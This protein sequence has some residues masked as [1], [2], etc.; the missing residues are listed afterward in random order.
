M[1]CRPWIPCEGCAWLLLEGSRALAFYA[2]VWV[3]VEMILSGFVRCVRDS[4]GVLDLTLTHSVQTRTKHTFT[5]ARAGLGDARRAPPSAAHMFIIYSENAKALSC[6]G[7]EEELQPDTRDDCR[8]M[9]QKERNQVEMVPKISCLHQMCEWDGGKKENL[10]LLLPQKRP[11]K[12][13]KLWSRT[14][15]RVSL[16]VTWPECY[17]P[18]TCVCVCVWWSGL[19]YRPKPPE[20]ITVVSGLLWLDTAF[21]LIT[22]TLDP[23]EL[24]PNVSRTGGTSAGT[25]VFALLREI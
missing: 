4:W 12:W 21:V 15:S 25:V 9:E 19:I 6:R 16:T 8:L 10:C 20:M 17:R 11:H 13:C 3:S 2:D 22:P 5:V 7:L 14:R 23:R 1:P 18:M 24:R